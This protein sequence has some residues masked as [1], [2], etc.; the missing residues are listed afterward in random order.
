METLI[1]ELKDYKK[2]GIISGDDKA[3]L[4]TAARILREGGLVAFPTE[5]V[6]GLGG[7]ALL[8]D[9]AKRIYKA[10]GRPSDNPLIVHITGFDEIDALVSDHTEDARRLSRAFWPGPLTLIMPK[11]GAV[12]KETTG[13]LDTIAVRM[14]SHKVAR[15]LLRLSGVAVAAPS[16]N[17]SGRP[18]TTTAAHCIVDLSGKVD[19]IVD[20]GSSEYGVESTI[21]DVSGDEPILLRPGA[22][23][24]EMLRSVLGKDI[25]VDPAVVKPLARDE[26]PKA[27]GMKYRH[28]AP[29]APLELMSRESGVEYPEKELAERILKEALKRERKGEKIGI[30][31]SD[32]LCV[33]ILR[34]RSSSSDSFIATKLLEDMFVY[35]VGAMVIADLGRYGDEES[36]AHNLFS[37]LREMDDE[38]VSYIYAESVDEDNIGFAVMNRLKK[39]SGGGEI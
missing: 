23:T 22:V 27:P 38:G 8:P 7:N 15:E 36:F 19:A 12:P 13:G 4:E 21:V 6:Y 32:E 10:K 18:S 37:A 26:H 5:T 29:K 17:L 20:G 28:Y 2:I 39:A 31:C 16:A 25:A 3:K 11:A 9:A 14:P 30:V 35:T 24:I 33:D 1:L 34:A